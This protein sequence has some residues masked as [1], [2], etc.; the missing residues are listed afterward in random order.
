MKLRIEPLKSKDAHLIPKLIESGMDKGIFKLT[1]FSSKG[2]GAYLEKLLTIPEEHRRVKLYGAFVGDQLAGYTEWRIF[3][4]SLFLNN[5]YV[6]PD[7]QGLGLGKSLLEEHGNKL[8]E[9]YRKSSITLDVFNNN[10]KAMSWYEKIG[11]VKQES[12]NWN[13]GEQLAITPNSA[14]ECYIE[15]YPN[16]EAEQK[17]YDFSL[18]TCSTKNGIYQIGRI[19]NQ[20]YRLTNTE[21]LNNADLLHCLYQV[22]PKRKILLLSNEEFSSNFSFALACVSSRMKL[23]I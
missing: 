14:F 16:A 11:F 3:E 1:I 5:I 19:K 21:S 22:D 15:N 8:M 7:Y 17:A 20:F 4:N 9:E 6:F 23:E 12:I 13:V 2:Y 10:A 18:F